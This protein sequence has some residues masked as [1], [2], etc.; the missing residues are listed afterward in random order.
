MNV[1]AIMSDLRPMSEVKEE[2]LKKRAELQK[3]LFVLKNG[4][5]FVRMGV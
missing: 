1:N 5:L 2:I 3:S 4:K